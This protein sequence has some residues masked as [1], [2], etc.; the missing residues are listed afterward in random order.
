LFDLKR[1]GNHQFQFFTTTMIY[2]LFNVVFLFLQRDVLYYMMYV[3]FTVIGNFINSLWYS[4]HLLDITV[5]FQTL[6]NVIRAVGI[7]K[8]QL[9]MTALL[10]FVII[11][12]Y[13]L[14]GFYWFRDD[15]QDQTT[16]MDMCET[17]MDCFLYSLDKGLRNGG[18]VGD[19]LKK[20][21]LGTI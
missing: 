10:C 4:W 5:R 18:G 2:H 21:R 3:M 13:S 16:Y 8:N 1:D 20:P 17:L 12:V 9:G 14:L 6:S 7:N 11:Y 15:F 19:D